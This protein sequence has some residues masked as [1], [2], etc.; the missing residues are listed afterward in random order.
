MRYWDASSLVP[1]LVEQATTAKS[2]DQLVKDP[3][4]ATWWASSVE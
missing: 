4:I 2:R 3:V 1:Q